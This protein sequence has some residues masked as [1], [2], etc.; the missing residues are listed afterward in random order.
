MDCDRLV[1]YGATV[2]NGNEKI[3]QKL[4]EEAVEAV[5]AAVANDQDAIIRESAD[6]LYHLLVTWVNSGIAPEHVTA[7]LKR[8]EGVSGI[9]EKAARKTVE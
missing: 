4:G 3:A 6:L 5:V 2:K 9:A 7:E 1:L 8:R